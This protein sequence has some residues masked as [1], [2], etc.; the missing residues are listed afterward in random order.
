ME[1]L[2]R[3]GVGRSRPGRQGKVVFSFIGF[4]TIIGWLYVFV[5][6]DLFVIKT[7]EVQGTRTIDPVDVKREVW[8]VLDARQGWRPWST[9][10]EWFI[11]RSALAVELQVRFFAEQVLV[12]SP[13]IDVLR[14]NILERTNKL[15]FHSHRQYAW[16]DLQGVVTSELTQDEVKQAQARLL[17]QRLA[18]ADEPPIIHRDLDE[19]IGTGFHVADTDDVKEWVKTSTEFTKQ[20]I[21]YREYEPPV[22][23]SSTVGVFNNQN[24]TDVLVDLGK[25]LEPQLRSYKVYMQANGKEPV[26]EYIDIRIPGRVYT[27]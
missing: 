11:D 14:L 22:N 18:S 1:S 7:I 23:A 27:K 17:G 24:G 12:D 2:D 6:S 3:E 21:L 19:L 16:I 5:M 13:S 26:S 15:I 20:G 10:H 9:R 25:P 8:Q 4:A